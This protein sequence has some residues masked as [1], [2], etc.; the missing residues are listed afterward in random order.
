MERVGTN[1]YSETIIQMAERKRYIRS[2]DVE[3]AGVPRVYLTRLVRSGALR[4]VARGL[5][6]LPD[7]PFDERASLAEVCAILPKTTIS[8]LS[9]AQL[10]GIT[11]A[12]PHAVWVTLTPGTPPPK[13]T[14]VAI[15]T[16]Y[17]K[18]ELLSGVVEKQ[19]YFGAE[20]RVTD[21]EKTVVD[22]FRYRSRVG[23]ELALEAL[24]AY[25]DRSSH[26]GGLMRV[27]GVNGV[28]TVIRP[29]L[30]ALLS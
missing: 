27:A 28:S 5:Y 25:V 22:M 12:S 18:D 13:V 17:M 8:L 14:T 15:E 9:A 30:T 6:E 23:L 3:A 29:Y 4:R 1:D 16:V 20:I 10:H 19:D 24:R 26:Y 2:R 11:S 21:L 7:A